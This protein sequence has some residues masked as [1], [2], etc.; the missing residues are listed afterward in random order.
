MAR[1]TLIMIAALLAQF[2]LGMAAN[3]FVTIAS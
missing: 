3:L 2:V 1:A